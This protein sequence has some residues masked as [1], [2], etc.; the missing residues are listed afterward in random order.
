M[1]PRSQRNTNAS[2]D[3]EAPQVVAALFEKWE[4]DPNEFKLPTDNEIK[5]LMQASK[6]YDR[7]VQALVKADTILQV[8]TD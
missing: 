3:A 2:V 4:K 1:P 5:Q 7:S 6:S 8:A